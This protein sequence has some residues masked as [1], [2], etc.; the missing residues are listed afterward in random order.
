MT[1]TEIDLKTTTVFDPRTVVTFSVRGCQPSKLPL[2]LNAC[3]VPKQNLQDISPTK[4]LQDAV[5][6]PT[7]FENNKDNANLDYNQLRNI[8]VESSASSIPSKDIYYV[9][10]EELTNARF[11]KY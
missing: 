9:P 1:I 11:R 3:D 4:I 6:T 2:D 10:T 5:V 8:E 7:I